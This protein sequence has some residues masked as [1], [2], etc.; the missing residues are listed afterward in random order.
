MG[1]REITTLLR[2]RGPEKCQISGQT[3]PTDWQ[4]GQPM[5]NAD[6]I[7]RGSTPL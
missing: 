2:P 5:L 4:I 6:D 1:R 3:Q 7:V